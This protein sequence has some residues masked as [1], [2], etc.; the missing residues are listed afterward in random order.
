MSLAAEFEKKLIK[1]IWRTC[2]ASAAKAAHRESLAA[3]RVLPSVFGAGA[4]H[5]VF[6]DRVDE[7]EEVDEHLGDTSTSTASLAA[8]SESE[9]GITAPCR[10]PRKA[11]QVLRLDGPCAAAAVMFTD[12]EK[13]DLERAEAPKERKLVLLGP[14]YAGCGG[15]FATCECYFCFYFLFLR[16]AVGVFWVVGG[17]GA[18]GRLGLI[19]PEHGLYRS[20]PLST[21]IL[22][23]LPFNLALGIV[24]GRFADGDWKLPFP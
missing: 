15:A 5:H 16:G 21:R 2:A 22:A 6:G 23:A 7:V 9:K 18:V 24:Q 8:P 20:G 13:G 10:R 3:P 14:L 12:P 19:V 4:A 17:A 1:H 11:D